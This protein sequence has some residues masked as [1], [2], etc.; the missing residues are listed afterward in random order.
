M[1]GKLAVREELNVTLRFLAQA[2][3]AGVAFH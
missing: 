1:D 3:G 2:P